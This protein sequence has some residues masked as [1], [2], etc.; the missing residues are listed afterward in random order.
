MTDNQSFWS[1]IGLAIRAI[2]GPTYDRSTTN[3]CHLVYSFTSGHYENLPIVYTTHPPNFF[4][5]SI[6][7]L[8]DIVLSLSNIT[9]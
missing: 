1:V 7:S 2:N 3:L 5:S 8:D 4:I 9:F 6:Y